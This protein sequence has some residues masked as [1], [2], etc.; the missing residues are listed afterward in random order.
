[1]YCILMQ[2]TRKYL[3]FYWKFWLKL[4]FKFRQLRR[5]GEILFLVMLIRRI[6]PNTEFLSQMNLFLN[7]YFTLPLS[8]L[9]RIPYLLFRRDSG[10]FFPHTDFKPDLPPSRKLSFG[11]INASNRILTRWEVPGRTGSISRCI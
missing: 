5:A 11:F 1:M 9:S 10:W 3:P 7:F 4:K 2:K 8:P 6:R